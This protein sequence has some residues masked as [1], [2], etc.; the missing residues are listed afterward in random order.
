MSVSADGFNWELVPSPY[1]AGTYGVAYGNGTWVITGNGANLLIKYSTDGITWNN[2]TSNAAS[3]EKVFFSNG[4]FFTKKYGTDNDILRSTDGITWET[5]VKDNSTM[6]PIWRFNTA[7]FFPDRLVWSSPLNRDL[8][9]YTTDAG[10]TV[11]AIEPGSPALDGYNSACIFE[12]YRTNGNFWV[13][14]ARKFIVTSSWGIINAETTN[15]EDVSPWSSNAL[16]HNHGYLGMSKRSGELT[17]E[18]GFLVYGQPK[19]RMAFWNLRQFN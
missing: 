15:L 8:I 3:S 17:Q 19:K 1:K 9:W 18:G 2:N 16:K 6:Q 10:A 4:Y 12:D 5:I 11:N 13:A 7:A 14:G